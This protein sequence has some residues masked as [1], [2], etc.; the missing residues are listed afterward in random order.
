MW[1]EEALKPKIRGSGIMVSD[2]VNE[3]D[4][5]LRLTNEQY[6]EANL[7]SLSKPESCSNMD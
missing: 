4:G 7:K 6:K 5:Y 1:G 2:F 3:H